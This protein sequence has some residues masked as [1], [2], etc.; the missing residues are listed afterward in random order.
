M[1]KIQENMYFRI[2]IL[3]YKLGERDWAIFIVGVI[4]LKSNYFSSLGVHGFTSVKDHIR[5]L[6]SLHQFPSKMCWSCEMLS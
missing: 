1:G 3:A 4:L 5:S 6:N 2:S